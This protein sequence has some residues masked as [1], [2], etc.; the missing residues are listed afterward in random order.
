MPLEEAGFSNT[1]DEDASDALVR[2]GPTIW[3][4]VDFHGPTAPEFQK[5]PNAPEPTTHPA[6]VDS[7]ATESCIDVKLARD[8]GLPEVDRRMISGVGGEHEVPFYLARVMVPNLQFYQHGLFAGVS[9]ADGGQPHTVLIGRTFLKH[10]IM[11][12]DGV[13]GQVTLAR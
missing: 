9:L 2:L 6:L 8:I 4:E 7:G 10:F 3:V 12:Y 1:D 13:R 5:N 11:I